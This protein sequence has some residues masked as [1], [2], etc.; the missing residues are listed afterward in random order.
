MG[1]A[2]Q[3]ELRWAAGTIE[4]RGTDEEAARV[5]PASC[6]W[7]P[8]T[9]CFR[10]PAMAYA[11]VIRVLVRG[12]IDHED[13]ARRYGELDSGLQVHREPRPFQT[14][15]LNAWKDS[16]G[17]G[18]VVLPTGAG[19]SHVALMAIDEKRRDTLV[20]APTLDLVTQWYDLLRTS[21]RREVGVVGGGE[22]R[23]EP[24]TV[25]TYDSAYI[26]MEHR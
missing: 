15:A 4:I 6:V 22:H 8:R 25:T 11:D 2:R 5:L 18:M 23:V 10:A 24:L 3:I 14:T 17:R 1:D 19:K 9:R 16:G 13:N 12:G 20:V 26:H 7:D 21:F